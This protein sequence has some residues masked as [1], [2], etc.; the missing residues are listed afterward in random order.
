MIDIVLSTKLSVFSFLSAW[1]ER[2]A[3]TMRYVDGY[4]ESSRRLLR[5]RGQGRRRWRTHVDQASRSY[6]RC[7]VPSD[8]GSSLPPPLRNLKLTMHSRQMKFEDPAQGESESL[9]HL[10]EG[11]QLTSCDCRTSPG[12]FG[13]SPRRY[14]RQIPGQFSL[15]PPPILPA[16]KLMYTRIDHQ[17]ISCRNRCSCPN[18]LFIF[19]FCFRKT[20]SQC[21]TVSFLLS[22][23]HS[24]LFEKYKTKP[25]EVVCRKSRFHSLPPPLLAQDRSRW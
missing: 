25:G 12:S 4:V 17:R 15:L 1:D 20:F 10:D 16:Q 21:I 3:D 6:E 22:T 19:F 23:S 24:F 11:C 13:R 9:V 2:R 14:Y 18:S 7:L 5:T 8:S